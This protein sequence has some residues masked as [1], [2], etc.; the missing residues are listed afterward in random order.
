MAVSQSSQPV[1]KGPAIGLGAIILALPIVAY[2]EGFVPK[3]YIDPV[4]VPTVCFG[5]TDKQI[6]MQERFSREQCF[7]MLGASL[8]K[9]AAAIS[10]CI[11]VPLKDNEAAAI[12]SWGYNIGASAACSSTLI[13]LVNSGAPATVWCPEMRKWVYAKGKKLRGLEIRREKEEALCL[14][15]KPNEE[16]H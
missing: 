13:K 12:L 7:V 6:T 16:K 11:K 9:H 15:I 10:P 2:F 4:G 1:S 3:T 14:N 8:Q 5:E